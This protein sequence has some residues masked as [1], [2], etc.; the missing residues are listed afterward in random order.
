MF[1]DSRRCLTIAAL[2]LITFLCCSSVNAQ[3]SRKTKEPRGE[4][5]SVPI[6]SETPSDILTV[7]SV[8]FPDYKFSASSKIGQIY[9]RASPEVGGEIVRVIEQLQMDYQDKKVADSKRKHLAPSRQPSKQHRRRPLQ[10]LSSVN[11]P[12][13][14]ASGS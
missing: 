4:V 5:H 9:F 12:Q 8:L 14:E 2:G 13:D 3:V 1:Y 11:H 7:L 10:L 6:D